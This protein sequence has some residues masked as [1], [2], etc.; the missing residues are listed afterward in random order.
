MSWYSTVRA[1]GQ[2]WMLLLVSNI[3]LRKFRL[4]ITWFN[5]IDTSALEST[6]H[7]E[8][9]ERKQSELRL[10]DFEYYR[11]HHHLHHH[12]HHH[13]HS[14]H[15][16]HYHRVKIMSLTTTF[17]IQ[18]F[19]AT[20]IMA[21]ASNPSVAMNILNDQIHVHNAPVRPAERFHVPSVG[22]PKIF[23]NEN[24][25]LPRVNTE[26]YQSM[27]M[28][29]VATIKSINEM[30]Q[31]QST[32]YTPPQPPPLLSL[33]TD[34]MVSCICSNQKKKSKCM[35]VCANERKYEKKLHKRMS[36]FERP[37]LLSLPVKSSTLIF[38]G[39][40]AHNS[41]GTKSNQRHNRATS[42]TTEWHGNQTTNASHAQ[43][44]MKKP[45]LHI[46]ATMTNNTTQL[47]SAPIASDPNDRYIDDKQ[48]QNV[49]TSNN[50]IDFNQMLLFIMNDESSSMQSN[51]TNYHRNIIN[52]EERRLKSA[53]N[54]IRKIRSTLPR[55]S[56]GAS[57]LPIHRE[58]NANR[59]TKGQTTPA[60][61]PSK[62]TIPAQPLDVMHVNKNHT[63]IASSK[64]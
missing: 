23:L 7:F 62:E 15:R 10:S 1:H 9:S 40:F 27:K 24:R 8:H 37:I 29:F 33:Q 43:H 21:S 45:I 31:N 46:Y 2:E 64:L 3:S 30:K 13:H 59:T 12:H 53:V 57:S 6:W 52:N 47:S 4:N 32:K 44:R 11:L 58:A 49:H 19:I 61:H 48:P 28:P 56:D 25:P 14:H 20:T 63:S 54:V 55:Q 22:S 34:A 35:R 50:S 41:S 17:L 39:S 51:A 5:M 42:S 18:L 16:H 26:K 38:G 36:A 60:N